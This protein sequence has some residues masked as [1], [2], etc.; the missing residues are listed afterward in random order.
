MKFPLIKSSALNQVKLFPFS[1]LCLMAMFNFSCNKRNGEPRVLVFTKTAG[2]HHASIAD[3]VVAIQK[4]GKANHF[5]VD[6]T[7][8]A[9]WFTE[10]TLKK[11]SA[12]IFLST[13]GDLLNNKQEIAFQRYMEA[14]G[15][16]MGIHAAAD[17]E[18]DWKWYGRLVG[19]YFLS[20]PEQQEA[21]LEVVDNKN[22][23]TKHL[24][25]KW[26]R[27]DEWYNFKELNK[28]VHVLIKIDESTY[29][30]GKNGADHPMAWYHEFD[31]GRAFYTELGHTSAS[32]TDDNYLKHILGGIK[33]AIGENKKLDYDHVKTLNVPD[34]DRFSKTDINQG[35]FFEPTEMA[36]L[37]DLD[38]LV[39]QRR[40]ELMKY[41]HQTKQVKQVGFLN[42]Y[43]QTHTSG[44]NAEEGLLGLAADPNYKENHFIYLFY[45]PADTSVNRLS[46]FVFENDQ[47]NLK[48]E[49]IIL[50]FYSQRE[51]C[52][53]TGGSIAF[54]AD[55]MLF[56]ST[57]D[58]STPFDQPN[59]K[60]ANHGYAPLDDRPGF[61]NYD[62]RRS[63]GNTNDLRGKIIRI[64]MKKDGN[65]EIPKG[66][67]F[68]PGQPKT[69]PE[70]YVMGD[71]NPYRISVDKKNGHLY[72]G[73][74]GPDAN[75][76]S[77][78][79]RGPRG[80]D[81]INQAKKAGNFGWP[82]FI[83]DNIPY[84]RYNY[85]TGESGKPYDP[86]H[87]VN[88][89]KNNTGLRELPKAQPAF[90]WYPYGDSQIFPQVG[91]GGRTA[92][93]GPVYY[94][95]DFS[96][97]LR[98]PD[99][100]NGKLFIYDWIR[101]W[102]KAVT[103]NQNGDFERMEPFMEKTKFNNPI[104]MEVGPDGLLYVLEYG[105]GW[106]AKNPDAGIARL[107][108]NAGNRPPVV[109]QLKTDKTSSNLPFLL[110]AN[111]KASDPENDELTYIWKIGSITKETKEPNL[112]Y[113]IKT[114]G[115]HK[116]NVEVRDKAGAIAK[117][118]TL[119]LYAGNAQPKVDILTGGNKSFYF[120]GKPIN[121]QIKVTDAE[122]KFEPENLYVSTDYIEGSDMAGAKLGHQTVSEIITG[123]NIMLS[124]DCKS[125]H[126]V[127]ETS[128][129]PAFNK[130]SEKYKNRPDAITYL[131]A[132]IKKGGSGVWGE[133]AM[134]AHPDLSDQDAQ[135]ITKWILSLSNTS[136]KKSSPAN[137]TLNP[138][139]P[140]SK[141]NGNAVFALTAT[142]TDRGGQGAI[143]LTSVHTIYF[144]NSL[145]NARDLKDF[146]KLEQLNLGNETFLKLP[147]N[148][149][150]LRNKQIDFTGI[151]AIK[152]EMEGQ[153]AAAEYVVELRIDKADGPKL[154]E[155][156]LTFNPNQRLMK[157]IHIKSNN[158]P[159]LHDVYILFKTVSVRENARP[160]LKS[161]QY[162]PD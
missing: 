87:P 19:G 8:N 137:G 14:G 110:K 126:K 107:D 134:P 13:T 48:S 39:T 74:V 30:G 109:T 61:L 75:N 63:A 91:A 50:Q 57:G 5:E 143:P 88:N 108:Y 127:A 53:H 11:Y 9:G 28:D 54:G 52:C 4:L 159:K 156:K 16:F 49:K 147:A 95:E 133:N 1:L 31:G 79:T 129:G 112:T 158:D 90:I 59:Q 117:S 29:T 22:D 125:C 36:I 92:M 162:M 89:S 145:I 42:V 148:S 94:T 106:F 81:E 66:N 71:R 114:P 32:Y 140:A 73:E 141:R 150:W 138:S 120:A 101:G 142:Y 64:K 70:I 60:Y 24:P 157:V 123:K 98:Y 132:K 72:W 131:P 7:S 38:I 144:K 44:V 103:M 35:T 47:L 25:K 27:K 76:D 122:E 80:Y 105:S 83:A 12:V 93:T 23:A 37:P 86:E 161:I 15:G 151:E 82:F 139:P 34:E 135:K 77:L 78:D 46:R 62:S 102:I 55:D 97:K 115:E 154:G 160:I 124:L 51:I 119:A 69:K 56:V 67:L 149:G 20:H 58:N 152:L 40:G 104:D 99:Y 45:S 2:Y 10:D 26:K 118:E 68:A 17:A 85:A 43:H 100:Y 128:I 18:Y 33:Y 6:T 3:G 111:V 155:A 21:V 65:Y 96:E 41:D 113:T 146:N 116:L 136:I 121:Y 130:V 153:A 84:L